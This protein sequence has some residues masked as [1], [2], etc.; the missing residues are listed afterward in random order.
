MDVM[1]KQGTVKLGKRYMKRIAMEVQLKAT[2]EKDDPSMD[3]MLLQGVKFAFR[4]H[5]FAGGFDDETMH[6]FVELK[7]L[8]DLLSNNQQTK[9]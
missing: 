1:I 6:A 4:I 9:K 3:Y 2:M 5:Q 7:N 8:V